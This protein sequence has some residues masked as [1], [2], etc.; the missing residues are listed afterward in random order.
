MKAWQAPLGAV[1]AAALAGCGTVVTSVPPTQ[2]AQGLVYALP[3]GQVQVLASRRQVAVDELAGAR[4]ALSDAEAAAAASDAKLRERATRKAEAAAAS[5]AAAKSSQGGKGTE[6]EQAI[7]AQLAREAALATLLHGLSE[8]ELAQRQAAVAKARNAVALLDGQVGKWVET[9]TVSVWPNVPDTAHRFVLQHAES[10]ARDDKLKFEV[11]NG[12]LSGSSAESTGQMSTILLNVA[13]VLGTAGSAGTKTTQI[14][15]IE[16][17]TPDLKP[18]VPSCE[19]YDLEVRFDPTHAGEVARA[20][21]VL[22]PWGLT[23]ATDPRAASPLPSQK[24]PAAG[25]DVTMD[26]RFHGLMYRAQVPVRVA[27]S[28]DP[29]NDK[30]RQCQIATGAAT[31]RVS[32]LFPDASTRYALPIQGAAFAKVSAKYSFKDGMPVSAEIDRPSQ[33]VAITAL[34]VDILKALI[35]VPAELIKLRVDYSSAAAAQA[36]AQVREAKAQRD[37]I[38][39]LEDLEAA[40]NAAAAAAP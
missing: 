15:G 26:T 18:A 40:R 3:K 36:E 17:A 39:A 24:V 31:A 2:G 4:K 34:P 32:G 30:R 29:S 21:G 33:L 35:S 23:L 19:P 9:I 25:S 13:R 12:L 11:S 5:D 22:K 1:V 38:K 28:A 10:P 6:A 20:Q 7:A 8:A 37:L 16:K 14:L 27:V